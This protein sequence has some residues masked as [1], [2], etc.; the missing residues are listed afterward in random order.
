M[1]IDNLLQF[2]YL[3]VILAVAG[4]VACVYFFLARPKKRAVPFLPS[5]PRYRSSPTGY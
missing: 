5:R 2:D 4:C 3:A 1:Q